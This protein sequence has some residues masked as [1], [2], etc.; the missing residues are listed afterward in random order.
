MKV[1]HSVKWWGAEAEEKLAY[2]AALEEAIADTDFDVQW[3]QAMADDYIQGAGLPVIVN[4]LLSAKE[5]HAYVREQ[6]RALK[7]GILKGLEK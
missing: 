7:A 6:K 5:A 4:N 1:E 3:A 2:K